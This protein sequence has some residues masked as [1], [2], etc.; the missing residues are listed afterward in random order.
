MEW[1]FT[2]KNEIAHIFIIGRQE[3]DDYIFGC[4]VNSSWGWEQFVFG[5]ILKRTIFI[6]NI[7]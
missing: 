3:A 4:V 5:V 1:L 2:C 7:T 6:H